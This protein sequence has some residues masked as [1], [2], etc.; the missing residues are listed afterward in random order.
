MGPSYDRSKL[1]GSKQLS[2]TPY[3][4]RSTLRPFFEPLDH[5]LRILEKKIHLQVSLSSFVSSNFRQISLRWA[6]VMTVQS[7]G[8]QNSFAIAITRVLPA[9]ALDFQA[10]RGFLRGGIGIP[11]A[12]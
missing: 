5:N 12:A 6:R 7:W 10:G 11:G 3:E 8:G 1:G 9:R 4:K 2:S